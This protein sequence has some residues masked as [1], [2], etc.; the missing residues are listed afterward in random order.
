[1]SQYIF[2][3]L[4]LPERLVNWQ[5]TENGGG[6]PANRLYSSNERLLN[7][8]FSTLKLDIGGQYAGFGGSAQPVI[9]GKI[10]RVNIFYQVN[11]AWPN[12]LYLRYNESTV[13]PQGGFVTFGNRSGVTDFIAS[14]AIA[15]V[16]T[17]LSFTGNY[18]VPAGVNWV[19]PTVY[20]YPGPA[21]SSIWFDWFDLVPV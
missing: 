18:V 20:A 17:W 12:G 16:N 19:S 14:G 4:S 8:Q 6:A 3:T 13:F 2:P 9:P 15:T 7:S 10:Y 11:A 5:L 1:M 21:N